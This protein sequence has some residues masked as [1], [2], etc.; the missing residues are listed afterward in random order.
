M[1]IIAVL[2]KL[3]LPSTKNDD[4]E[5]NKNIKKIEDYLSKSIDNCN[6]TRYINEEDIRKKFGS[7]KDIFETALSVIQKNDQNIEYNPELGGYRSKEPR[8][9]MKCL[10]VRFS[11]EHKKVFFIYGGATSLLIFAAVYLGL[12]IRKKNDAKAFSTR[13]ILS[14]LTKPTKRVSPS[15]VRNQMPYMSESMWKETAKAVE[16]NPVIYVYKK[17]EGKIWEIH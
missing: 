14:I 15:A 6:G 13:I 4:K 17:K 8:Y 12:L 9:S 7:N 16:R 10:I 1:L 11:R 2:F 3:L 5:V